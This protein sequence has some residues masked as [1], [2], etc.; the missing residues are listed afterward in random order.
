MGNVLS[1]P[2]I[3][4]DPPKGWPEGYPRLCPGQ[5]FYKAFGE[6]TTADAME[7]L[8]V[9]PPNEYGRYTNC[10]PA[11][12]GSIN[13]KGQDVIRWVDM[14]GNLPDELPYISNTDF[15]KTPEWLDIKIPLHLP[16]VLG[17]TDEYAPILWPPITYER[18]YSEEQR[19][20][21]KVPLELLCK[22]PDG[23]PDGVIIV[24]SGGID[25]KDRNAN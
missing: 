5:F 17:G 15:Y 10:M 24:L 12:I 8:D 20:M 3:F 6:V 22:A 18:E 11:G 4:I 21:I 25:F 7:N 16:E 2:Y 1:E 19:K 14:A 13:N 9:N 23:F